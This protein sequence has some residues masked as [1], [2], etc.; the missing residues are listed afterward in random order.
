MTRLDESLGGVSFDNLIHQN[1]PAPMT[2]HVSI[3]ANQGELARGSVIGMTAAGED[4][5]LLG[6]DKTVTDTLEVT[7]L[8][9]TYEKADLDTSKLKVYAEGSATPA[10][11]TTD[12]TVEYADGTLTITLE[13][14]GD[15]AEE[16]S[17]DI[18]CEITVAAMA[19]AKYILAE[20]VDTG[21]DSAVTAEAYKAGYFNG[22][23]LTLASGYTM[24]AANEEELR[25]LGIFLADAF[26]V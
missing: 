10:T 15:L 1:D 20:A 23:K 26:S 13:A 7:E 5:I 22:N 14:G 9:A 25:T 19:K 2:G 8:V 4:G 21:T 3:A 24:T 17:I 18:E 11:I 16:T 6:S 12:Y